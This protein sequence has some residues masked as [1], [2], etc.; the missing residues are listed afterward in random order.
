ML[1]SDQASLDSFSYFKENRRPLEY[2]DYGALYYRIYF[3]D[4]GECLA[5]CGCPVYVS[6]CVYVLYM[7]LY[8]LY[9]CVCTCVCPVYVF[10]CV[11]VLCMCLYVCMSCICVCMCVCHVPL[12]KSQIIT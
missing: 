7:C 11:Y 1:A 10:V 12:S 2:V 4:K 3:A 9:M 8:V 5:L 6:V